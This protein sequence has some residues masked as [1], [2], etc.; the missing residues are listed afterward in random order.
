[1]TTK[2][3]GDVVKDGKNG[4][5]LSDVTGSAISTILLRCLAAPVHLQ[6]LSAQCTVPDNFDLAHI[7]EQWTHVFD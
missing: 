5:V 6:K 3:C 7:G 2:F 4:W 1:M